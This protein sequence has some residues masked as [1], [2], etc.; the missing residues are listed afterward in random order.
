MF[1]IILKLTWTGYRN[2]WVFSVKLI[3]DKWFWQSKTIKLI[4]LDTWKSTLTTHFEHSV[5]DPS[6][7]QLADKSNNPRAIWMQITKFNCLSFKNYNIHLGLKQGYMAT[8]LCESILC[9]IWYHS[10]Y[11]FYCFLILYFILFTAFAQNAF[12]VTNREI[13]WLN[14]IRVIIID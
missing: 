11:L 12:S 7:V 1:Q 3:T 6:A 14:F 5:L 8:R 13:Q 2:S 9:K 4:T 10:I